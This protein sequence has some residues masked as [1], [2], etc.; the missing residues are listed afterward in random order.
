VK[1]GDFHC[2]LRGFSR[3]A[4]LRLGLVSPGMEFATEMVAKAALAGYVIREVPTTLR[5]DGRNRPPHLRT[6]R[7]G[8]RH[9]LFMLLFTPRWLFLIPG[10]LLAGGGFIG[11]AALVRGPQ[12][13]GPMGLDVHSMLYCSA[14][15][16]IGAQL[17]HFALLVKWIAVVAGIVR[18]PRWVTRARKHTSVEF[19]LVIGALVFFAGLAW[20]LALFSDW[21]T[22]G[23]SALDTHSTMRAVIPAATLMALGVQAGASALL[24]GALQLAWKSSRNK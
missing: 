2:G 18:E 3:D 4:I 23:F 1:V 21:R 11:M 22:A 9:L 20:T 14:A 7:D 6:W 24:A 10:T 8:W 16:I 12:V 15:L 17:V 13:L 19:G 5:P